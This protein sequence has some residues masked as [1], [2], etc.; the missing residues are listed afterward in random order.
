MENHLEKKMKH[1]M[2]TVVIWGF[3][4]LSGYIGA[5]SSFFVGRK[6]F[7]EFSYAHKVGLFVPRLLGCWKINYKKRKPPWI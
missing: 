3:R 6:F 5:S 2:K 4:E 7:I 1:E